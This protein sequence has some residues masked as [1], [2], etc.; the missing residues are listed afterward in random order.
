MSDLREE[1]KS[2]AYITTY[3]G[4]RFRYANPGPFKIEDIAHSLSMT[5][6][7][8]GH[9][10]GFYS[11]AQHSV[12]VAKLMEHDGFT[13]FECLCGLLHDAHEAYIG[14]IP[15]PLKWACP[16]ITALEQ[17]IADAMRRALLGA[18][19]PDLFANKIKHYDDLVLHAEAAVLFRPIPEWV[20]SAA[21]AEY[22]AHLN[23]GRIWGSYGSEV[24]RGEFSFLQEARRLGLGQ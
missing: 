4:E 21:L 20:N 9:S 13:P 15:T 1:L 14:D 16:E 6:R 23:Q 24:G 3:T 11:V 8:R 18:Y 22:P 10:K 17:G 5:A 7:F 19:D 12:H 2:H